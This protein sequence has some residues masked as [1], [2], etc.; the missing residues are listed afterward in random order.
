MS[1]SPDSQLPR[2]Q[3]EAQA[4]PLVSIWLEPG[5]TISRIAPSTSMRLYYP[6]AAI[7]GASYNL[8]IAIRRG[9]PAGKLEEAGISSTWVIVAVNLLFGAVF[10]IVALWALS[11][12]F[13]WIARLL[14][15]RGDARQVRTV[16]AWSSVPHIPNLAL[17]IVV[18]LI[19]G[20]AVLTASHPT[21]TS[22]SSHPL[23]ILFL[24]ITSTL[25]IWGFVISVAGTSTIMGISTLRAIGVYLFGGIL[26]IAAVLLS[27]I[28]LVQL[29]KA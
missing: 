9:I 29:A 21:G 4:H 17:A 20:T 19:G 23:Q 10:G 18:L 6:L 8:S 25:G 3:S 1:E 24:L 22:I 13:A 15:G 7:W 11:F 16:L 14:G 27:I 2:S 28:G 26:V 5:A 12:L